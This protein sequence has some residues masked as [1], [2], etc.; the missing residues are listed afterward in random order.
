MR[1]HLAGTIEDMDDLEPF[2][3]AIEIG[4]GTTAVATGIAAC[5]YVRAAE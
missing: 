5:L 2:A 3:K 1:N 4:A